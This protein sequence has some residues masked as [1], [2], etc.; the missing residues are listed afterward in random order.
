MRLADLR[1]F[2]CSRL[3]LA[4]EARRFIRALSTQSDGTYHRTICARVRFSRSYV[5]PAPFGDVTVV[6]KL[7]VDYVLAFGRAPPPVIELSSH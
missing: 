1:V 7:G 2:V 5:A 6:D 3:P 4:Q